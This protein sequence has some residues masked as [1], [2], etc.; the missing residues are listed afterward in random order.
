LTSESYKSKNVA[1]GKRTSA[2]TNQS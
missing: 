2:N 1:L